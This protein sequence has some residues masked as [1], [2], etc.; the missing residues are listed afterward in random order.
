MGRQQL[1][2]MG[3]MP[4]PGEQSIEQPADSTPSNVEADLESAEIQMA[5]VD[6]QMRV[7]IESELEPE[8]LLIDEEYVAPV[9]PIVS[10]KVAAPSTPPKLGSLVNFVHDPRTIL[11][12]K[13]TGTPWGPH[14]QLA[15]EVT[16]KQE[17]RERLHSV[18]G[19]GE[20]TPAVG[21]RRHYRATPPDEAEELIAQETGSLL[22]PTVEEV[23]VETGITYIDKLVTYPKVRWQAVEDRPPWTAGTWHERER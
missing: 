18:E 9:Q 19:M 2:T 22:E 17:V 7:A 1:S 10:A 14:R 8:P 11:V 16:V 4:L 5:Q 3:R 12:A 6:R 23:S 20:Q 15:L 21:T 13:V